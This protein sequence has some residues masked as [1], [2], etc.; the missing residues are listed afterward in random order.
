MMRY[1]DTIYVMIMYVLS[2]GHILT[3]HKRRI[4]RKTCSS[5]GPTF[6]TF[7]GHGILQGGLIANIL[8]SSCSN[9]KGLLDVKQS[10]INPTQ[11]PEMTPLQSSAN[12]VLWPGRLE[13]TSPLVEL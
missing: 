6:G 8:L 10:M 9:L 13:E 1:L 4:M 12:I 11:L 5:H 3:S 2:I 7:I